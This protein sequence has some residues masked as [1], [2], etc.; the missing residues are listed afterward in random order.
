MTSIL[1]TVRR[2]SKQELEGLMAT[3]NANLTNVYDLSKV[4]DG[5]NNIYP[6][7]PR[8]RTLPGTDRTTAKAICES[9]IQNLNRSYND[10]YWYGTRTDQSSNPHPL[11][12][13]SLH[14]FRNVTKTPDFEKRC[15]AGEIIVNDYQVVKCA[16]R[17]EIIGELTRRLA[18]GGGVPYLDPSNPFLKVTYARCNGRMETGIQIGKLLYVSSKWPSIVV[19][20]EKY[21][22]PEVYSFLGASWSPQKLYES[23]LE[24]QKENS[25]SLRQIQSALADANSKDVDALTAIAEMPETIQSMVDGVKLI[26]KIVKDARKRE[27]KIIS[28][29]GP[30]EKEYAQKAYAKYRARRE[31]EVLKG[32]TSKKFLRRNPGSTMADYHREVQRRLKRI[33]TFDSYSSRRAARFRRDAAIEIADELS[34]L[35]LN[36][37]YNI[38]PTVYLIQDLEQAIRGYND[39]AY[40]STR[41]REIINVDVPISKDLSMPLN[42]HQRV[43]IKRQYNMETAAGRLNALLM[44]DVVVTAFE[45]IRLWSIIGDWVFTIGDFLK[46]I[47][48]NP[49]H[50]QQGSTAS[51]RGSCAANIT[52]PVKFPNASKDCKVNFFVE[53]DGYLRDKISPYPSGIYWNPDIDL[54]RALSGIAFAWQLILGRPIKNYSWN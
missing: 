12:Q 1:R 23:I 30:L 4:I 21:T 35:Q 51:T 20:D 46:S 5:G 52:I 40:A 14:G 16:I 17:T 34:A 48:W 11:D 8:V 15:R 24:K 37:Q 42:I 44:T 6:N 18:K 2:V 3:F 54:T 41:N 33:E 10:K 38:K 53:Y 22:L 31:R 19:Y 7:H 27:F 36:V 28:R 39:R 13:V 25:V 9:Y 29:Q 43:F 26:T 45:K 50:I 32:F 47:N 49:Q